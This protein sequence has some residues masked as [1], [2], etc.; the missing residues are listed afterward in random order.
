[1]AVIAGNHSYLEVVEKFIFM[2]SQAFTLETGYYNKT[3]YQTTKVQ[4]T[5]SDIFYSELK[6]ELDG[7]QMVPMVADTNVSNFEDNSQE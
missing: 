6:L 4:D 2:L 3:I 5:F 7:K 1:M